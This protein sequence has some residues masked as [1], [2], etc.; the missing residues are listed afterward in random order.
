M[1]GQG[2][3]TGAALLKVVADEIVSRIGAFT[4][5]DRTIVKRFESAQGGLVLCGIAY[6]RASKP[7]WAPES[8]LTDRVHE[9]VAIAVKAGQVAVCASESALRDWVVARLKSARPIPVDVIERAF[10]GSGTTAMWLRGAHTSTSSKPDAKALSG[11]ALEDALDP[12]GDQTFFYS[13]VRT[14]VPIKQKNAK[15]NSA[16]GASPANA[17]IWLNRPADWESFCHDLEK[18][19]DR[20][21]APH[22]SVKRYP[23]LAQHLPDLTAAKNAYAIAVVPLELLSD[24]DEELRDLAQQWA[25]G[26]EFKVAATTGPSLEADVTIEGASVGRVALSVSYADRVKTDASWLAAPTGDPGRRREF[27][28]RVVE[29]DW[30]K[31]YYEGGITVAGKNAYRTT[32]RD[33]PFGWE[34]VDLT[35]YEVKDEK[36]K[37]HSGLSLSECIGEPKADGTPDNSL[38]GYVV[39]EAFKSGWLASDDGSMELADF[40]H[41]DP[42]SRAV[43]LIHA[44]ASNSKAGARRVSVSQ[45]EVVVGQAVKN[46]RHLD[47]IV[48]ADRLKAGKDKKIAR[49]VWH[50]GNRVNDR[51]GIIAAVQ[52]LGEGYRKR[53]IVFQPQLTERERNACVGPQA[54]AS[55]ER[56]IRMKQL[57]TLM[58]SARLSARAVGGDLV[59]WG[60][61]TP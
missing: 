12:L 58:L 57:D 16:V 4:S 18:V 24:T 31:I 54:T 15:P 51:S 46:L 37:L 23:A 33:Q 47:R 44:K 38:F 60:D 7:A 19:I 34:F 61:K 53:V 28:E 36:P 3:G 50:D 11:T 55:G 9:F 20:A 59:G 13:A 14:T 43:T 6:S 41:V 17:R 35:G 48:L 52:A 29:G 45:Y 49:A 40:I 42:T 2:T 39:R 26:A 22:K 5:A 21:A 10:V 8:T 56:L 30:L 25:Y 1:A 27:L 32:W